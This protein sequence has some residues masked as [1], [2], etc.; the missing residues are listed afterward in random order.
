MERVFTYIEAQVAKLQA[1]QCCEPTPQPPLSHQTMLPP[2]M[3]SPA[4]PSKPMSIGE[5]KKI[6]IVLDPPIFNEDGKE[7]KVLYDH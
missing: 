2:P 3:L 5:S 6:V 4:T 7:K 1:K